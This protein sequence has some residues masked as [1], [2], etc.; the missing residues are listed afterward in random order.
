MSVPAIGFL[1]H[2]LSVFEV[3]APSMSLSVRPVLRPHIEEYDAS[4]PSPPSQS[5]HDDTLPVRGL[6]ALDYRHLVLLVSLASQFLFFLLF[7]KFI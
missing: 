6:G 1:G 7:I 4:L 3:F 5:N 2:N